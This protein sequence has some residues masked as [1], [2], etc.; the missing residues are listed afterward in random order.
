MKHKYKKYLQFIK[1]L[2]EWDKISK[3]MR[4]EILKKYWLK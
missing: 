1:D 4:D 2:F 3:E